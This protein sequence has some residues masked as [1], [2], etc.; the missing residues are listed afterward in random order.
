MRDMIYYPGFETKDEN[1]LK[2]ALLYFDVLRPIIPHTVCSER[3]YLSAP[4]RR[5]M[6]ETDLIKPYRPDYEEGSSASILACE[7]FEEF[8]RSPERYGN[9]FGH[10]GPINITE[11]WKNPQNQD[12]TLFEGKYNHTFF[13]FRTK[14]RIAN[15]CSE[16]I[17]ISSELAFVYM[18][19]LADV[20]SKKN[21]YEMITDAKKYSQFLIN[22]NFE[23]AKK[24]QMKIQA[25]QNSIELEIPSNLKNI[26]LDRII[27][28]RS[29]SDFNNARKA[30]IFEIENLIESKEHQSN[31][32]LKQLLSYKSEFISIAEDLVSLTAIAYLSI[33]SLSFIAQGNG[34]SSII[35]ALATVALNQR[36]AKDACVDIAEN[37]KKLNS[38]HLARR[39]VANIKKL[40]EPVR[41]GRW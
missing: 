22:N 41:K 36:T 15:R 32:S 31:F 5:I 14:N 40:N 10:Y 3:T 28:L 33:N 11:K 26:P 34:D 2:F 6:D 39:Y 25:V 12:C 35:P 38:K 17:S 4:F 23:I 29:R 24:S 1:W 20:I 13:K 27:A 18:S 16:G 30:Y 8:L 7:Q 21:D 9:Y 37:A 19:L